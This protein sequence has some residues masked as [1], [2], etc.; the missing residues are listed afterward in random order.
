MGAPV[1]W[2]EITSHDPVRLIGFYR[3]LFDWTIADSGG[4][5]YALVDTGGGGDAIGGGIGATRGADDPGGTTVYV[6]VDDL[7]RF[8]DKAEA[9]G[10][11]VLV[12]PTDLPGSYGRFAMF[13]DPDGHPVGLW[14]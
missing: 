2:F 11:K 9:L 7:Q 5:D 10:G 13:A 3:E 4:P 8:L 14:S 12:E 1:A 6:R